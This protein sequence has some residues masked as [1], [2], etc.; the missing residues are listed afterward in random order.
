MTQEIELLD[1][2]YDFISYDD[3]NAIIAGVCH[4][5]Y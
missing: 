5:R 4:A 3:M 2:S 1:P